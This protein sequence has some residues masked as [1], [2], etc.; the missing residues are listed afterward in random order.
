MSLAKK[1]ANRNHEDAAALTTRR[2]SPSGL[3][4]TLRR[5]KYLKN[6]AAKRYEETQAFKD[7]AEAA[8]DENE[9]IT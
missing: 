6:R 8:E 3:P 1:K 7:A 9:N 4:N 2:Y 5:E